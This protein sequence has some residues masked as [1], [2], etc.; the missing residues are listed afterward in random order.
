MR[1]VLLASTAAIG[2]LAVAGPAH[3]VDVVI[4]GQLN[5]VNNAVGQIANF[6]LENADIVT[7]G[8]AVFENCLINGNARPEGPNA[9]GADAAKLI[10]ELVPPAYAGHADVQVGK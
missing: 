1:K 2:L 4:N 10:K 7:R 6:T 8:E 3:A 9:T 5:N